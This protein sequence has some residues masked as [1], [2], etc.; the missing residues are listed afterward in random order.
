M[1]SK[2]LR[3]KVEEVIAELAKGLAPDGG[4]DLKQEI[5]KLFIDKG[6]V[7]DKRMWDIFGE[8]LSFAQ[9]LYEHEFKSDPLKA[10]QVM[11]TARAFITLF[12]KEEKN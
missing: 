12:E 6:I 11:T 3:D 10:S 2:E 7:V 8:G 9:H 1:I 5:V 4:K